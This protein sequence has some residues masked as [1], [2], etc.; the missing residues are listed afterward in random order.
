[1]LQCHFLGFV[2]SNTLLSMRAFVP[3]ILSFI[4]NYAPYVEQGFNALQN[5]PNPCWFVVGAVVVDTL[6]MRAMVRYLLEDYAENEVMAFLDVLIIALIT[7]G[8]SSLG[9][10]AALKTDINWIKRVQ[11]DQ[12]QRIRK[13]EVPNERTQVQRSPTKRST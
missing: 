3:L 9:T 4:S 6:G 11:Q 10:I 1:M 7:G 2:L 13:L 5:I 12:E 8:V